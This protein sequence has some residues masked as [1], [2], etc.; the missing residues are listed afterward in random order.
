MDANVHAEVNVV[1]LRIGPGYRTYGDPFLFAIQVIGDEG[2]ATLK[3]LTSDG[4][5]IIAY[6]WQIRARLKALGFHTARW[7]Q[8]G[9]DG[10]PVRMEVDLYP[11]RAHSAFGRAASA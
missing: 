9:A 4:N 5:P 10:K 7:I 8:T 3:A 11:E 6:R 1:T 2:V